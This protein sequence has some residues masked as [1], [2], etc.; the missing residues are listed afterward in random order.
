MLLTCNS[1]RNTYVIDDETMQ[2]S[3]G[4][5]QCEQCQEQLVPLL[6]GSVSKD[7][8]TILDGY[9]FDNL[10]T[11]W[12]KKQ[13]AGA[14]PPAAMP[15]PANGGLPGMPS[16]P[17]FTPQQG[18]PSHPSIP[19]ATG[20]P[21]MPY[22]S[23]MASPVP[24]LPYPSRPAP[25]PLPTQALAPV[26]VEGDGSPVYIQSSE[27]TMAFDLDSMT[28]DAETAPP[29]AR[30]AARAMATS[31]ID[32]R[33]VEEKVQKRQ[34]IV[35][36]RQAVQH[37]EKTAAI[38]ASQ[39]ELYMNQGAPAAPMNPAAAPVAPSVQAQPQQQPKPRAVPGQR[40]RAPQQPQMEQGGGKGFL[41]AILV[42]F[43]LLLVAGIVVFVFLFLLAGDGKNSSEGAEGDEEEDTVVS[44]EV[45]FGEQVEL[46]RSAPTSIMPVSIEGDLPTEGTIL[47]VTAEDGVFLDGNLAVPFTGGGP[48]PEQLDGHYI[49]ELGNL[50]GEGSTPILIIF[51]QSM[52]LDVVF[53]VLYSAAAT[54][55]VVLLAGDTIAN[56]N[57][58]GTVRLI[59]YQWPAPPSGSFAKTNVV[60]LKLA[61][62]PET[63][64]VTGRDV[65]P[66]GVKKNE[67]RVERLVGSY[68]LRTL[69]Q[70]LAAAKS[71]DPKLDSVVFAPS[72]TMVF[73]KFMDLVLSVRGAD[74]NFPR[75]KSLY[76]GPIE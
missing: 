71:A 45:R 11:Q 42:L 56:P 37:H 22:P 29:R 14:E 3:G 53:P 8:T 67:V 26:I 19:V 18:A 16:P 68:D 57:L 47:V 76:L 43:G 28:K 55:R 72:R 34:V 64:V 24:G 69:T 21:G 33:L 13:V 44:A 30:P 48:S 23:P 75:F 50:V 15:V 73:G 60:D 70:A 74:H 20:M 25:S 52:S 4:V 66:D 7:A 63:V 41:F 1:C 61:V 54:G 6:G 62:S 38:D 35:G 32:P 65:N 58:L 17:G 46:A 5:V 51:D 31:N 40:T 39:V 12:R 59:P 36:G 49:K 9:N 27:R 2:A 10:E